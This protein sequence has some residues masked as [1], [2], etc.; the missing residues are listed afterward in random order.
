MIKIFIL[1]LII[2]SLSLMVLKEKNF[3]QDECPTGEQKSG[4]SIILSGESVY[5]DKTTI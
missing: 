1:L 3:Q 5:E 2:V 4:I